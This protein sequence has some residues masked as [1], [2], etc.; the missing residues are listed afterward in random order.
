MGI[1]G[2]KSMTGMKT[3]IPSETLHIDLYQKS[4]KVIFHLKISSGTFKFSQNSFKSNK[5]VLKNSNPKFFLPN[6]P[7]IQKLVQLRN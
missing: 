7:K 2:V 1:L 5:Q 3:V 6:P 4:V